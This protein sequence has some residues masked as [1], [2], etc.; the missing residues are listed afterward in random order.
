MISLAVR[1]LSSST[2][3]QSSKPLI[4]ALTSDYF[5]VPRLEDAA[6]SLGFQLETV[7]S[8]E[9]LGAEGATATRGIPLTEPLEGP[10]AALIRGIV[11]RRPAL[12]FIDVAGQAI[13]WE[14]WTQIM[15]TSAA[16]RR[17]PIVAFGP[18]VETELLE[19]AKSVGADHVVT[20]GKLQASLPQLIQVHARVPDIAEL[21]D[22]CSGELSE[23]AHKGL[24]RLNAG[25]YYEAHED[26]ENAWIQAP[27]LEGYLYR[28]LL[29]VSVAYLHVERG[30]YAGAMK[31]L[32]RVRQWI[33]PLPDRCRGVD[34]I[35]L[36]NNL[37]AFVDA[38]EQSGPDGIAKF[39]RTNL[40]PVPLHG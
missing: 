24:K 6:N 26:L 33:E 1:S 20:R 31:M 17:I 14:R 15:K 22:A 12:I 38:L 35:T 34:V 23:L 16:T 40:K 37:E 13:P 19:R 28:S 7:D 39:D 29:Q 27:E 30:N 21:S 2:V 10:D 4:L 36:R 3:A 18:H 9:A 5:F 11:G 8:P 32:L 25:Q